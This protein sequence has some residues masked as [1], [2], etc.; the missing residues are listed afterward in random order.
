MEDPR[1]WFHCTTHTYGAWLY[2]DPRGFRTRHHREHVEG[3]YKHPPPSGKYQSQYERSKKL[4][5]Q[6]PVVLSPEWRQVIG[7]A[8]RERLI[9]LGAQLLAISV[10]GQHV[11]YQARIPYLFPRKWTGVAKMHAWFVARDRGWSG[12]LWAKRSKANPIKDR[13]HQENVFYY[14]LRHAGEGAW[15]WHFRQSPAR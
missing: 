3:D 8:L 1:K 7:E 10:S 15:V 5:K 4:L 13:S 6:P 14:I 2:G 12:E 11:H 9:E